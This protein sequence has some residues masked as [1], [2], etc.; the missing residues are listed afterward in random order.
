MK[1][2]IFLAQLRNKY[3]VAEN[4]SE[5]EYEHGASAI[6]SGGETDDCEEYV[7]YITM[8]SK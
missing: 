6:A 1:P 4:D 2:D 5:L 3:H 7:T 8:E